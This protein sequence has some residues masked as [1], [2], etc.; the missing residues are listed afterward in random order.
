MSAIVL[1]FAAAVEALAK[2]FDVLDQSETS[3][4]DREA[5]MVAAEK[6][7][8]VHAKIKFSGTLREG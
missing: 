5:L 8:S 4:A 7:A 6:L 1:A 2:L 3:E